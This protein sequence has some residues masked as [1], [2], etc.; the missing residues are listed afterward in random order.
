[1]NAGA[2]SV[3]FGFAA[4]SSRVSPCTRV[5]PSSTSRSGLMYE[6]NTRSLTRRLRSS[7][8]PISMMRSPSLGFNP[9]VSVSRTIC[10]SWYSSVGELV[11][12]LVLRMPGVAAHPAPFYVVLRRELVEAP[13]Q[14]LVLYR[15][16]V[17]SAPAATL[18]VA[19]PGRDALHDVKRIGVEPDAAAALQR[20]QRADRRHKLHAIVGRRRLAAPKLFLSA[21]VTQQ[22]APAARPGVP[23]A[24]PVA[25]DLDEAFTHDGSCACV[26][27]PAQARGAGPVPDAMRA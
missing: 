2:I 12:P 9:V 21:V 18:P 14:V 7:T 25:V 10:F 6:W 11:R 24:S 19:D 26:G 23:T 13:P 5:A 3:N 16:F 22:H 1:M 8:Q 15:L 20:L 27:I 17:R 4:R